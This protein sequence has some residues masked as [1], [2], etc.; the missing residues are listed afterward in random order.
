VSATAAISSRHQ[1][2]FFWMAAALYQVRVR[3]RVGV[4]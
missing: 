3:V 2:V 4:R 1:A